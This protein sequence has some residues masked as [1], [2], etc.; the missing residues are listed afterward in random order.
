[1][2][3]VPKANDQVR[4]C[5]DLAKV[6]ANIKREF[7]PLTAVDF[8]LGT[9]G[10]AKVF[11][12]LDANSAFWQRTLAAESKFLTTFITPWGRFCLERLR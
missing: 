11:S 3:V 6:N 7:H 12:K 8:T 1:M 5:V 2:V 10:D 4:I 9:L